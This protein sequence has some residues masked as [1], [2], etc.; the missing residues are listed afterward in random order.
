ML[1]PSLRIMV[2]PP[3]NGLP[4]SLFGLHVQ[5]IGVYDLLQVLQAQIEN[6]LALRRHLDEVPHDVPPRLLGQVLAEVL[7]RKQHDADAALRGELV[8]QVLAAHV[9]D[10]ED[11]EV[12]G[13]LQQLVDVFV[14]YLQAA[15]VYVVQ[16]GLHE[17][18][19]DAGEDYFGFASAMQGSCEKGPGKI[20]FV[21][22]LLT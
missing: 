21:G 10:A 9:Q 16:E 3:K 1:L 19:V 7:A 8:L 22:F 13:G 15:K 5:I 6:L 11:A 14:G 2:Y 17:L 12:V 20:G 4:N 18:E